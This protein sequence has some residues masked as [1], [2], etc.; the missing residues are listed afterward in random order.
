MTARLEA[1]DHQGVRA[2]LTRDRRLL[3]A[4]HGHPDLAA[5]A[6]QRGDRVRR[7]ATEGERRDRRPLGHQ[8]LDLLLPVVVLPARLARLV[9]LLAQRL[10]VARHRDRI[11]QARRRHEQVHAERRIPQPPQRGDVGARPVGG[12]VAGGQE[13]QPTGARHRGGQLG[14]RGAAAK[15]R[16]HDRHRQPIEDAHDRLSGRRCSIDTPW[17][18]ASRAAIK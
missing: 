11:R 4:G 15:R 10:G 5:R 7:R 17:R 2:G 8:Q 16:L 9:P 12:P 18:S 13:A 6:L 14:S 1:L 3:W